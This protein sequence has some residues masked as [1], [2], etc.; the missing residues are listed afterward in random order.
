MG[1]IASD[2]FCQNNGFPAGPT[3]YNQ[4]VAMP[5]DGGTG[6]APQQTLVNFLDNH[7]VARFLFDDGTYGTPVTEAN[8]KAA[9]F[10]DYTWDG[11]PCLYY[12]TEQLFHG[13][14]DPKN[15]EDMSAGNPDR[16]FPAWDTTNEAFTY[17]HD[18]IAMRK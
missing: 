2:A 13:G 4:P 5:A 3:Y 7:D 18:L 15:R 16:G 9:L 10:Y 6:L 17:V 11:I 12:G 1:R 14:V 8:L